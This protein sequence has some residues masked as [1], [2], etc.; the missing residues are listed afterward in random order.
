MSIIAK[1]NT[2]SANTVIS[3]S[4]VNANFDTIYNDYN[5]GIAAANLASNAVTTAKIAD[6]NVTTAKIADSNVTAVKIA[7]DNVTAA[8]IDWASTGANGGIWW[9]ELGRTTLGSGA[10]TISVSSFAARKYLKVLISG[11]ATGGTISAAVTLNGDTGTNYAQRSAT[12]DSADASS[13]SATS[14]GVFPATAAYPQFATLD[15]INIS[16]QEKLIIVQ[17]MTQNSAG[18]G[19]LPAR[20]Y[21]TSKW[22]N[23]AAQITTITATNGGTGDYA[24]GSEMVVL[25][26]N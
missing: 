18:A 15:I 6:S 16:A 9:E 21:A 13:T 1:P 8:K 10:D 7:D 22:A 24:I 20:Y 23:T 17:S 5:G 14:F 3:S 2:F 4:E 25:G 11:I 12:N 26:H 19:N